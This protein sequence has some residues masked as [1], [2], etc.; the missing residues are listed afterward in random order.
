MP[1]VDDYLRLREMAARLAEAEA[2]ENTAA[3]ELARLKRRESEKVERE[4]RASA[5]RSEARAIKD[6]IAALDRQL[7]QHLTPEASAKLEEEGL[8]LLERQDELE[9]RAAEDEEFLRGFATTLEEIRRDVAAAVAEAASAR[10]M[11]RAEAARLSAELPEGWPAA[12][13]KVAAKKLAHGPFSRLQGVQCAFCRFTVSR[14]FESEV[15]AQLLLKAC[16]GCGR[17]FLPHKAVAG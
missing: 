13:A 1:E 10:E 2:R 9:A 16:P 5:A 3:E 7:A 6:R 8:A 15:E 17:L 12:F 11:A 14:P 4:N